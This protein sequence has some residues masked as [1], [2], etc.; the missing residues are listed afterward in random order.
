LNIFLIVLSNIFLNFDKFSGLSLRNP[1]AFWFLM[2]TIQNHGSVAAKVSNNNSELKKWSVA[3]HIT[4]FYKG[5]ERNLLIYE[6]FKYFN[7]KK[8]NLLIEPIHIDFDKQT[9]TTFSQHPI[10]F[11]SACCCL[12][13]FLFVMNK[14]QLSVSSKRQVK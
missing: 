3:R 9:P 6:S 7:P 4:M 14:I 8:T 2:V 12:K 5:S 10:T 1:Y 13:F 11:L